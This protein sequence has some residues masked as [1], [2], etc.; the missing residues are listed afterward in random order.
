M[1]PPPPSAIQVTA[2]T[3]TSGVTLPDPLSAPVESNEIHGRRRKTNKSQWVVAAP[4]DTSNFRMK[5]YHD[6][7]M[8]KRWDRTFPLW[9]IEKLLQRWEG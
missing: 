5:S 8:A 3:D 7:P 2:V 6:K 1:A 9:A 4:S